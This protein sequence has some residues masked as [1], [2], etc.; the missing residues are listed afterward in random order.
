VAATRRHDWRK[1]CV[2]V[3]AMPSAAQVPPSAWAMSVGLFVLLAHALGVV[4][5][6]HA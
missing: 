2:L 1:H 4:S 3:I 6:I 5:S